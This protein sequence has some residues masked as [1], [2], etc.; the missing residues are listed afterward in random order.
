M[1]YQ[2][3]SG[4]WTEINIFP[5]RLTGMIHHSFDWNSIKDNLNEEI[6]YSVFRRLILFDMSV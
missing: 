3:G 1:K 5:A 6:C 2:E 4:S